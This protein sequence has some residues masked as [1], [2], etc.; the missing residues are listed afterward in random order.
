[1][2]DVKERVSGESSNNNL[3]EL[4]YVSPV[5]SSF[6]L[7][8]HVICLRS[9]LAERPVAPV[10]AP[11]A[12]KALA[13]KEIPPP[14]VPERRQTIEERAIILEKELEK[15]VTEVLDASKC[16]EAVKN[17]ATTH[18]EFL[19][20]VNEDLGNLRNLATT[21]GQALNE[22]IDNL[23]ALDSKTCELSD[24]LEDVEAM[25]KAHD[26]DITKLLEK[27]HNIQS[28]M[29]KFGES[30]DRINADKEKRDEDINVRESFV[31][32]KKC[33]NDYISLCVIA[34]IFCVDLPFEIETCKLP[35]RASK[36]RS[37]SAESDLVAMDFYDDRQ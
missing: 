31:S 22:A 27:T 5:D 1:M 9:E 37:L 20:E 36:L 33:P 10:L 25:V 32:S 17:V 7:L 28:D 13:E 8:Y 29:E 34:G 15:D 35:C 14:V 16:M 23:V 24:K 21:Q 3:G 6:T 30:M 18:N 19:N 2:K 4:M 12:I 11:E 26:G